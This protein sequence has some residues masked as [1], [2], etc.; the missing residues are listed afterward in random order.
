TPVPPYSRRG[1]FT[2]DQKE[3]VY[4]ILSYSL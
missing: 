2:I 4:F 1:V 3:K